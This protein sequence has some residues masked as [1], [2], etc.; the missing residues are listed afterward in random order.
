[1]K[2]E[3]RIR[4]GGRKLLPFL[5]L[6]ACG[7]KWDA[8]SAAG[9]EQ[10]TGE[11]SVELQHT[12]SEDGGC[13]EEVHIECDGWIYESY[14]DHNDRQVYVCVK[15]PNFYYDD[16]PKTCTGRWE[17]QMTCELSSLG[18]F[19]LR[20]TGEGEDA[21][22]EAR[23]ED[24]NEVVKEYDIEWNVS[25]AEQSDGVSRVSIT[26]NRTY[27]ATLH[28]YDAKAEC[29]YDN[30]LSYTDLSVPIRI[31]Y[32][33]G[34]R[35]LQ[36]ETMSYGG[37]LPGIRVPQRKGYSFAG[38]YCG[39]T[40]YYDAEGT[41]VL[42]DTEFAETRLELQARWQT[43]TYLLHYGSDAD[44][45]GVPDRSVRVA[46]GE[47]IPAI[48]PV[49][50][51]NRS[52]FHFDGYAYEG[53]KLFAADGTSGKTWQ[54]DPDGDVVL[55][56]L[57]D[58]ERYMVYYGEDAD[59]D[60]MPDHSFE[61][62]YGEE[63][64]AV[65]V[66]EMADGE[67]FRGY[68]LD[69]DPVFDADGNPTGVWKWL[70]EEPILKADIRT[71]SRGQEVREEPETPQAD[72]EEEEPE[73]DQTTP[74]PQPVRQE[75]ANGS[76]RDEPQ[77]SIELPENVKETIPEQ[78]AIT[79]P[80]PDHEEREICDLTEPGG[81]EESRD[82]A[83]Y[84]KESDIVQ[85]TPYPGGIAEPAEAVVSE[86]ILP[87][88]IAEPAATVALPVVQ[89]AETDGDATDRGEKNH[90]RSRAAVVGTAVAVT[91][92][93]LGGIAGIHAGLVYLFA[94]AEVHTIC[95]DG[96]KKRLGKLQIRTEKGRAYRIE[97]G[98]DLLERCETDRVCI[99]FSGLFVRLHRNRDLIVRM[100][101]KKHSGIIQKEIYVNLTE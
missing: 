85:T 38:F 20:K 21:A 83:P 12:H 76:D 3:Y 51:E 15:C 1:M 24:R 88:C 35:L 77:P 73:Q 92:G 97:L 55:D 61:A 47:E 62:R 36:E 71:I 6:L 37:S 45:D 52:G 14:K 48:V 64:S 69:G 82:V 32:M 84:S 78:P 31:R 66:P 100:R 65:P 81:T 79:V 17:R 39:D 2:K 70:V 23:I 56:A 99:R 26:Q 87:E 27:S 10:T 33:D 30:T 74:T 60:G 9:P 53:Q 41:P 93:C 67:E 89:S 57:W 68:R 94:M 91:T 98:Q 8:I 11:P 19:V 13:Y 75:E 18:R 63:Y 72:E 22:L 25:G 34:D 28:W 44:G 58:T 101:E 46:Y 5:L 95:V 50:D 7:G 90:I 59:G 96:R 49:T 42:E 16:P 43:K 29:W 86:T 40:R 4:T 54:W 80:E